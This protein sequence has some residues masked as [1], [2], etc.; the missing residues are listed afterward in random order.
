MWPRATTAEGR[1]NLKVEQHRPKYRSQDGRVYGRKVCS[2]IHNISENTC[3]GCNFIV[4]WFMFVSSIRLSHEGKCHDDLLTRV[5]H[6]ING[7][8]TF[9]PQY[10]FLLLKIVEDPQELL[11]MLVRSTGQSFF[12]GGHLAMSGDISGCHNL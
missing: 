1:G 11:F 4:L 2:I 6:Y 5:S 12:T 8:Q 10:P 9:Q 3:Q 7:A